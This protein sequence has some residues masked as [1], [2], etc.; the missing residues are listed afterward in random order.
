MAYETILYE[1]ANQTA[2]VTLNR[3]TKLNAYTATMGREIVEAVRRADDDREVRVIILTGA[4]RAFCAGADISGFADNINWLDFT[5]AL[6]FANACRHICE[7]RPDLW[8]KALLQLAL[9]VGRNR[10]Y[11]NLQEAGD[12]WRVSDRGGFLAREQHALFDH[13]IVEPI[14]SCHRLKMLF[15]LEDELAASPDAPWADDMCAAV[16]RYLQTPMKRRHGLRNAAQA[17]DFV[18]REG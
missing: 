9:F 15:A 16:N 18:M 8:P 7:G 2:T 12:Q 11:V 3:P 1:V 17:L 6:T 4:W 10:K 14:V 13:A 5:H